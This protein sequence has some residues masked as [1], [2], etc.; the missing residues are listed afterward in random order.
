MPRPAR[1][2]FRR[3]RSMFYVTHEGKQVPLGPGPDT[4]E[5]RAA[6]E[7][8]HQQLIEDT[9]RR[10][11]AHLTAPATLAAP[12]AKTVAEAVAEFMAAADKKL[13]A[14]KLSK[15]GHKNYRL[16]CEQVVTAFG[17]RPIADV[18]AEEWEGWAAGPH[19]PR[20]GKTAPT[21]WSD[22]YQHD[23]LGTVGQLLNA[24]GCSL[25]LTRPA[26]ESRGA[27]TCLTDEQFARVLTE[28]CRYK[29]ARGDLVEL[30]TALR[31]T[32][33]RPGELAYLE[34]EQVDWANTCTRRKQHKTRRHT[35]A[36]RIIHFNS[37]AMAVLESQRTRYG[38]GL[39][40]RTRSG[41]A[42]QPNV[43]VKRCLVISERVGFRV[44]AYGLGRHSF[45]TNALAAGVPDA[46][47]A[48]LL[49]QKGTGMLT[50]HYSHLGQRAAELKAAAERVAGRKAAG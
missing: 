12:P 24:A 37:A 23:Q 43:I 5:N 11:V 3:G 13:A 49:G 18:A 41:A 45:A 10:T 17:P 25:K 28:V 29:T 40:F 15:M 1:P 33:A 21:L 26:K 44:I 36:D 16:T 32:G 9:V 48:E 27:D 34:V 22:S 19:P 46:Y 35:G 2:W 30:L 6:A 42:Y 50:R 38:T 20:P 39:L 47:V 31:E 14:G 8:A 4:P 7:A